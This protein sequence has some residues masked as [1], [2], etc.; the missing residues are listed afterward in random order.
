M[1]CLYNALNS[2]ASAVMRYAM[3]MLRFTAPCQAMP[4]PYK[5]R[6]AIAL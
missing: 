3:P 6:R 5:L 1:L 2:H 4:L